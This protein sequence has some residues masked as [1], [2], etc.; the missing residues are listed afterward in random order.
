MLDAAPAEPPPLE[1]WPEHHRVWDLWLD[2]HNQWRMLVGI[3]GA[4]YQGLDHQSIL[5][6]MQILGV[7][8]RKRRRLFRQLKIME[9][10]ALA[11]LNASE[12]AK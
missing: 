8:A 12:D 11:V 1:V 4:C 3:G 7:G 10:A 5:S 2:L 6:T 9:E